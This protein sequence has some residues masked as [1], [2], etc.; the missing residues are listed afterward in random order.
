MRIGN[1]TNLTDPPME[2]SCPK[3][4]FSRA[5]LASLCLVIFAAGISL[6][7][8]MRSSLR[9]VAEQ[10][11]EREAATSSAPS[12]AAPTSAAA[13]DGPLDSQVARPNGPVRATP[14][15][16]KKGSEKPAAEIS[17]QGKLRALGIGESAQTDA[18]LRQP[19][20]NGLRQSRLAQS[21][22]QGPPGVMNAPVA[23]VRSSTSQSSG[24]RETGSSSMTGR[25]R[26]SKVMACK[27][28]S[29][30]PSIAR[31]G[32]SAEATL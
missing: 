2:P 6:L 22:M 28:K 16:A 23:E 4:N 26:F 13:T 10:N 25:R 15:I 8:I 7:F 3:S 20:Q 1:K 9:P 27:S 17:V 21:S 29:M 11:H 32:S 14:H 5:M 19:R 31:S 24:A 18:G 12:S 30:M